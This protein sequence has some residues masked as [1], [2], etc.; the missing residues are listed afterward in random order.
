M[1]IVLIGMPGAGKSTVGVLLAKS[2]GKS[3]TDTD[4]VLQ[5]AAGMKLTEILSRFGTERFKEMEDVALR[6]VRET[7]AVIATG[8]SAVFCEEGMRHLKRSGV[9]V[10][11]DVPQSELE[12]RLTE[13]KTRGVVMREGETVGQL[14][15]ERRP[16][17]EKYA[18]ITVH[19][20]RDAEST[21]NET[22]KA[23]AEHG[24]A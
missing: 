23:L 2:L 4:L 14:L 19:G 16:Y 24:I 20:R 8:G 3:F 6:S 5:K 18:D 1:N 7:D 21:V 12:S 13:I 11:L 15:E 9:I 22:V 10:Y 17:Y